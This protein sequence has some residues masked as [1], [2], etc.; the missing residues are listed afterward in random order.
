MAPTARS[1]R[2]E[3]KVTV[4]FEP[5]RLSDDCLANAYELVLPLV[6][7]QVVVKKKTRRVNTDGSQQLALAV[8][9]G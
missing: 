3:L 5:S 1:R 2:V 4:N 6:S 7:Q 8:K 9:H